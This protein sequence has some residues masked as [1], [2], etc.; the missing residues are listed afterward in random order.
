MTIRRALALLIA[1]AVLASTHW[2][3]YTRGGNDRSR[4]VLRDLHPDFR[5]PCRIKTPTPKDET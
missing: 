4:T 5:D 2:V 1:G 3:A